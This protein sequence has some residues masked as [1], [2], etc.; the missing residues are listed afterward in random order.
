MPSCTDRGRLN[1]LSVCAPP[2]LGECLRECVC[3]S[4]ACVPARCH[5]FGPRRTL[6]ACHVPARSLVS[7][8]V[9]LGPPWERLPLRP[10]GTPAAALHPSMG[11]RVAARWLGDRVP[12]CSVFASV[13]HRLVGVRIAD[14]NTCEAHHS[15]SHLRRELAIN[16]AKRIATTDWQSRSRA[17][18]VPAWR[19]L[20]LDSC[21]ARDQGW[22]LGQPVPGACWQSSERL[23]RARGRRCT[24][25]LWSRFPASG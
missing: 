24:R 12:V 23:R 11:R 22:P 10:R 3:V 16:S 5:G 19:L 8:T 9:D 7:L 6:R 4:G 25:P 21:A 14:G 20:V 18:G 1:D 13:C 15:L 2:A 17:S